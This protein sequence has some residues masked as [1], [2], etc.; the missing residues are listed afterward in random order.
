MPRHGVRWQPP[1]GGT[2][3][4]ARTNAFFLGGGKAL[5]NALL[6]HRRALGVEV[7]YDAEVDGARLDDGAVRLGDRHARAAHRDGRARA[8]CVLAAGGFEANLEWLR[9]AWGDGGRQ[10][11]HPRHAVQHGRDAARCCSTQGAKP[12]GDPTQFHAVAIDARAPKFDGGIVTRLDSVPF[13]IVVNRDGERF[14]DEGEDFWPKRYAIWGGLIAQ[15]PDQ[16]AYSIVDAKAI[17]RFMP[18]G[19]P[20][21]RSA[22]R[23]RELARTLGLDPAALRRDGRRASTPPCGPARFDHTALDDCRTEA[24][25]RRK[26]HWAQPHRH[27][28]VLRL[29]A[30]ARHHLHLPGRRRWTSARACSWTTASR[31]ANIFA[32]GEIMAGNILGSGYLAGFGMTIGTVFGRIAGDGGG[33]PCAARLTLD[34]STA[35]AEAQRVLTSA[36]PA[37]TA[38]ATARSSRRWSGGRRSRAATSHYLANLCHDCGA[39]LYACQYAP[40]HEFARQRAADRSPDPR[41]ETK[42]YAWPRRAGGCVIG[43]SG[44]STRRQP[45]SR[46]QRGHCCGGR[47]A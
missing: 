8:P 36:T 33:A 27:A 35:R 16:I 30:A 44:G 13:G 37:A 47:R 23:S 40:P 15:Q 2:L 46:V 38:R 41:V 34:R 1:L 14:Y 43:P 3:H 31:R 5:I 9:E 42:H 28:A 24:S 21:D 19:L 17:G 45:P 29:S 22:A 7:V 10:L 4:L 11:H 20:A 39:C 6:P 26:S 18:L 32:A 25:R 12:I